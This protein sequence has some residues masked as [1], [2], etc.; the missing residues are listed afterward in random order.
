MVVRGVSDI[1]EAS[2]RSQ[3]Q[4][5]A[6]ELFDEQF[7]N[8][9]S[10]INATYRAIKKEQGQKAASEYYDQERAKFINNALGQYGFEPLGGLGVP[11]APPIP[12]V[13]QPTQPSQPRGMFAPPTSG[14]PTAAPLQDPLGLRGG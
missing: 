12:T 6:S 13:P 3:I 2:T 9:A 11:A 5:R 8:R 7:R 10:G 4:E 14:A 1:S